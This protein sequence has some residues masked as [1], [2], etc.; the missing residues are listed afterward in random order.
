MQ[1]VL[2]KYLGT[3][4]MFSNS[5]HTSLQLRN[6]ADT[7]GESLYLGN[8]CERTSPTLGAKYSRPCCQMF[9]RGCS[10]TYR[11]RRRLWRA[12]WNY[13]TRAISFTR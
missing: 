2:T 7:V 10:C 12:D 9:S 8:V 13:L 1:E 11:G 5:V 3:T 4:I 6:P